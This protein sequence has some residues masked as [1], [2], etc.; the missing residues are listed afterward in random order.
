MD[1]NVILSESFEKWLTT[2]EYA[3]ST[4]YA[5]VRYVN[6]FFFYLK[7]SEITNLEAIQPQTLTNYN[8]YLQYR[9][10]KRQNGSLSNNYIISNINAIKRFSRYLQETGKPFFEVKIK[11]RPDKETSKII[12]S[13]SEIKALYKACDNSILGMRD[14]A[15]LS[16]Y[17]GCGL[18]RS[19]GVNLNVND[20]LLKE[21]RIHIRQ[22]KGYKERYIPMTEAVK[23][24]LENY[25]YVAREQIR[26]FKNT[27]PEALFLSMQVSRLCGNAIIERVHKLAQN[28]KLQKQTGLHILRHSIATHLLQ[29]GMTLEE[30]SQFLGHSSLE[31]TQI[32]THLANA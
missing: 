2:L 27:K 21:K 4:V 3:P 23:E 6:D 1:I 12:L 16:I 13:Q 22:G 15:I 29:S 11:T 9:K 19:E 14:R 32:Y 26:S 25:I 7:S 5:S 17:Y 8:K 30:V 10:N 20:V 18:R 24:D 28:A 31:S